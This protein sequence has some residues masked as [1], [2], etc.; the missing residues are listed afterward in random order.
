MSNNINLHQALP[1]SK[2]YTHCDPSQFDF[3]STASLEPLTEFI[4]Q[5]RAVESV[6]FAIGM[7]HE[8]YNLFAF[9]PQ[10]TGKSSLVREFL[11]VKSADQP[12]PD[13][14]C[15]IHNFS[16]PHKP[17]ALRLPPGRGRSLAQDMDQLIEDLLAAIPA[18]FE[19]EEYQ[20]RRQTLDDAFKESQEN[21]ISD[22]Q[23]VAG[24][25]NVAI[26]RTPMGLAVAPM[27]NGEVLKPEIF[28]KLA[29]K[30]REEITSAMEEVQE[31]LQETLAQ[32]P[33]SEK[34]H[35]EKIRN[36]GRQMTEVVVK[37]LISDLKQKHHDLPYV[38]SFL[39]EVRS[40]IV[41][42]ARDFL[43]DE[44]T[45]PQGIGALFKSDRGAVSP[46]R[47]FR[48]NVIVDNCHQT[49]PGEEQ[50]STTGNRDRRE[51]SKCGF[52][53][54]PVIEEDNPSQPHLIGRIEH[55]HQMGTLV[56]DFTM[57]K[58]GALHAANGGYLVLDARKLLMQPFAWETLKLALNTKKIRYE[59]PADAYGLASTITLDPEPIPLNVKVILLGEPELYYLLTRY[60]P[61][62]RKLF[63]VAADFE[64]EMKRSTEND[65]YYAR[66]I[67]TM[68]RD[69][70]LRPLDAPAVARVV[71][72]GARLTGDAERLTT[73]MG[74]INDIVREADYWAA[75]RNA[76]IVRQSDIQKA[77]DAKTH[78]SDRIRERLQEQIERDTIVINTSG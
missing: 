62:F 67:A 10:G 64:T 56:T 1:T 25:K 11:C 38:I 49:L 16:E 3:K 55:L 23:E 42:D 36:L 6:R 2:L 50:S 28:Q 4:G 30:E 60:D 17:R 54:A 78:R 21:T 5:D 44:M 26:I 65:H 75:K 13:D 35:R 66:L 40:D 45:E 48:V 32:V 19:G 61:E 7:D 57:I 51:I 14:W 69:E 59:S 8:G 33:K 31:T 20:L 71:E 74:S 47:R 53:G 76:K 63:K 68:G 24:E 72:F 46:L 18:V 77:I 37:H 9:G 22:L 70:S 27:K 29:K 12:V 15:Y 43:P 41:R 58:P 73:H 34:E 52:E 39:E